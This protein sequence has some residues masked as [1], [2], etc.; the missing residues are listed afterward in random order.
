MKTTD[1]D[2]YLAFLSHVLDQ[3]GRLLQ[4]QGSSGLRPLF[5]RAFLSF[6]GAGATA[7]VAVAL[8]RVLEY[9]F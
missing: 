7:G 6:A 3:P 1:Q 8:A 5:G 4:T 2:A 9:L